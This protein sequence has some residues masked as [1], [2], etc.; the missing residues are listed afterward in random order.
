MMFMVAFA[1]TIIHV[2]SHTSTN[3]PS[4]N[5]HPDYDGPPRPPPVNTPP[6][7]PPA[8]PKLSVLP[9]DKVKIPVTA[10]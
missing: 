8:T 6:P 5:S 10:Y 3:P 2:N 9:S 7:I 1:A 4:F